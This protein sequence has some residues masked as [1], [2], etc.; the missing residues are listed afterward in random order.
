M[1]ITLHPRTADHVVVYF[2]KAKQPEIRRTLPQKAVTVEEALE[3]FA[4]TQLP[5]ATSYGR[6]IHADGRY[7]GDVWIYA[8]DPADTPSAML[9]YCIFEPDVWG[10]GV[11]TDAVRYFLA[12]VVE[13]FGLGSVGAFSY[14]ENI[15]SIRVLEKNGFRLEEEFE[16]NGAASRYYQRTFSN[17]PLTTPAFCG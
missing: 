10:S 16:E 3:D 5:G 11:A 12:E 17:K 7:V 13:R 4:Q 2:E 9:S 8:I 14:T 6:T 15:A 1:N